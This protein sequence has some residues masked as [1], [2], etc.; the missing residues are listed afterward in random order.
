M[1]LTACADFASIT[2]PDRTTLQI[3]LATWCE[4]RNLP[5]SDPTAGLAASELLDLY[6]FG[7]AAPDTLLELIRT[8]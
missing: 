4:E 1:T 5:M 7:I 6:D 8:I 2:S 3:V